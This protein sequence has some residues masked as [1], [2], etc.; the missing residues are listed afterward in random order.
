MQSLP[1]SLSTAF[2]E[3]FIRLLSCRDKVQYY[4]KSLPAPASF[5]VTLYSQLFTP[6]ECYLLY[7][8]N[9][10]GRLYSTDMPTLV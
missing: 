9:R 7:R 2:A 5:C 6:P 10:Y 1:G 4:V 3:L 8:I